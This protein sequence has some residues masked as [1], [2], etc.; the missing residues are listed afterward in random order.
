ME[1]FKNIKNLYSKI[2][3]MDLLDDF[4]EKVSEE[5]KVERSTLETSW[6]SPNRWRIP[7]KYGV[8]ERLNTFTQN[9]IKNKKT[10]VH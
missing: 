2:K 8:P 1:V 10:T 3:E 7:K 4:L 5:F 6:F 9:Y